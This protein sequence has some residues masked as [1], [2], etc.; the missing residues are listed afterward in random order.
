ML[1]K[2]NDSFT[3]RLEFFYV[4]ASG[5][6][7]IIRNRFVYQYDFY[8]NSVSLGFDWKILEICK[9]EL[10][11][12]LNLTGSYVFYWVYEYFYPTMKTYKTRDEFYFGTSPGIVLGYFYPKDKFG[13]YIEFSKQ[14][15]IEN[16]RFNHYG[17]TA[18]L[19]LLFSL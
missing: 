14:F 3:L 1:K 12:N 15:L 19:I 11:I 2:I 10:K 17:N 6:P 8:L 18:K 16:S 9:L 5:V 13:I 7:E 4:T